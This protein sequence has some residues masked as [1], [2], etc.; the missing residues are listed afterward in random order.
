M[1]I[2][3]I[4]SVILCACFIMN[5]IFVPVYAEEMAT[6]T[7]NAADNEFADNSSNII[8]SSSFA[9]VEVK[10]V[11]DLLAQ[12]KFTASQGHGFA[13][14]RGNNLIDNIKGNNAKVI[15][16]NNV[17]NGA[18]RLIL[19]RDGTIILIQDKYYSTA[20]GSVNACFDEI[21]QF[22]YFDADGNPMQIEV[23]KDQ[24]AEA[25]E[26]MKEKIREGK[27]KGVSDPE[28]AN[29]L[30]RK[31]ALTYKQAKNL[32][33]AGNIDSLKYDAANGAVTA[34][35]SMG[36]SALLNYAV[37]RINGD[38]HNKA[39]KLATEEGLKTGGL[40]FCSSVIAGQLSKTG[41][42]KVFEPSSEALVKAFGDDFA[43]ALLVATGKNPA[44]IGTEATAQTVTKQAARVLRT[45]AIT[46]VVTTVVFSIP[47]AIDMFNGRIS[48][49]QFVKNFVV[50]AVSV[51]AGTAGY[52]AGSAAGNLIVPGVGTIPGGI[53]GSLLIGGI[54]GF[55]ADKI[56]DYITDD[57]AD[58]MYVIVQNSF[59]QKCDDYLVSEIEAQN[60][61][62]C[63]ND[64]LTEDMFKDMYQSEDREAFIDEKMTPLFETEIAKRPEYVAPTDEEMR[65]ILKNDLQGAV[66]I[67]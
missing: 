40:V 61:V 43:K 7:L 35:S 58:E 4:I 36:I 22:R 19:N 62:E 65:T 8:N 47:D 6:N 5:T 59:A 48:K 42:M 52:V 13:A 2:K 32:A 29:T 20:K 9:A 51:V 26:V 27:I 33:K 45:H 54:S 11:N 31:G 15:G 67:H 38:D 50:T 63:F 64:M 37:C 28:E 41:L 24:Y 55:A 44:V 3:G 14:E 23:P 57:D 21:G 1:K 30:V 10:T 16:D 34:V 17:K 12:S 49:K 39:A 56:A 25:V 60:I 18:D 46:A 66:F 53:V